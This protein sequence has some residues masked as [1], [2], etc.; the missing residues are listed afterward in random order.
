MWEPTP[1]S[2]IKH[3]VFIHKKMGELKTVLSIASASASAFA[4]SFNILSLLISTPPPHE[5]Q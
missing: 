1:G 5:Y 2:V 4:V 3:P